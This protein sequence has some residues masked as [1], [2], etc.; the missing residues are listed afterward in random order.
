MAKNKRVCQKCSKELVGDIRPVGIGCGK[1]VA[2]MV[3]AET[4]DRNWIQCQRCNGLICKGCC[5]RPKSGFCDSCLIRMYI[6]ESKPKV[7]TNRE[8]RGGKK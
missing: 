3:F 6:P 1:G 2:V 4:P 5:E 7:K 8:Q